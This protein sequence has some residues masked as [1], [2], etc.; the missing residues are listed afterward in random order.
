MKNF[1]KDRDEW[2][3]L[4]IGNS[5]LHWAWFRGENLAAAWDSQHLASQEI[6]EKLLGEIILPHLSKKNLNDLP[7]YIAS[8]VP[9]QTACWQNYSQAKFIKLEQIPIKGM[10]PTMGIDRALAIL[11]A[12]KVWELPCLV[13][14]AGTALT[15][16][17]IKENYQLV[18][19]AILPGLR[20]QLQS[21]SAKTAALPEVKLPEQLP[22]LYALNTPEAI[23]SGI[24]YTLLAGI[25]DYSLNW[26][27]SFPKSQIILTG[28]DAELILSYLQI[29]YPKI[30]DLI[31]LDSQVI[32]WGM[33]FVVLNLYSREQGEKLS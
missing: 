26:L 33:L 24:I 2:L 5:R 8:V 30:A 15:F 27:H 22:N 9:S 6:G 28:G 14:D 4:I 32:F 21:L 17:G 11:G 7:L 16:T 12:G 3:G 13:I 29:K 19:G 23:A 10:Y 1:L 20:L 18:G 25:R 31:V